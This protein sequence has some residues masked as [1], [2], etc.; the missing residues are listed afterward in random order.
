MSHISTH[1]LWGSLALNRGGGLSMQDQIVQFFR[2]AILSGTLKGGRKVPSSRR[3]S[4]EHGIS[5]TTAVEAYARLAAEGYLTPR[6]GSGLFVCDALPEDYLMRAA[7]HSLASP[8][9]SDVWAPARNEHVEAAADTA[10][11]TPW[12]PALDHFPWKDWARL[13]AQVHRERPIDAL[14]Y[15]DPR[16]ERALRQAIAEYLAVARGVSCTADQIIVIG[17]SKQ[18]VDMAVR[19]AIAP[20]DKVWIEEPGHSVERDIIDGAGRIPV[21]I[22]V[23]RAGIDV[24]EALRQA[25]EA[26]L[27]MVTPAHQFPL[28]YTLS[29]DRR[30][31]LLSWAESTGAYVVENDHDG[32][33]RYASRPRPPLHTLDRTGRV[34]YIGSFSNILAPG[35]RMAYLVAPLTL[36][37]AFLVMR[38]SLA[39]LPIQLV[40][41][42]FISGGRLSVHLRRMRGLYAQRRSDLIDALKQEARDVLE[43]VVAPEAGMHLVVALRRQIDDVAAVRRC[44]DNGVFVYPLSPCYATNKR[45]SGFIVGF[46]ST[47][48]EKIR[49]SVRTLADIIRAS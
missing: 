27:A 33:Y 10:A 2:T 3:L 4:T 1:P 39:P 16:G 20:G 9:V 12:I 17:S 48:P 42:R 41:A 28:G 49:P 46:A 35:L 43:V 6:P 19:A 30:L 13:T 25:P 8:A 14:G 45:R 40:L 37:D 31:A 36:V 26:R 22:P 15:G 47:R 44:R 38:A 29:L 7:S 32:E 34:I 5:R 18:G 23:D 11:L 21:P 24:S